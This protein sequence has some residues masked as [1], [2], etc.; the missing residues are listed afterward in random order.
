[1]E[2]VRVAETVLLVGS[3]GP[4]AEP[5]RVLADLFSAIAEMGASQELS[6]IAQLNTE[7]TELLDAVTTTRGKGKMMI[8]VIVGPQQLN[9]L[10]EVISF[11]MAL[12]IKST[13]PKMPPPAAIV[14]RWGD[15]RV[16]QHHPD[17]ARLF[18]P[19]K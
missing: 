11:G 15:G 12:R 3:E 13:L 10:G 16:S 18:A 9:P 8:E 7:F 17:Q 5:D 2:E 1:M 6:A 14:Y 19:L 4:A